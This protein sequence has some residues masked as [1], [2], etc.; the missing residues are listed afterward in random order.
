[1]LGKPGS[2]VDNAGNHAPEYRDSGPS[3][4]AP[5]N[6]RSSSMESSRASNQVMEIVVV[7]SVSQR[8]FDV[9]KRERFYDAN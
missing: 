8:G 7:F 6:H 2:D 9:H 3:A 5:T 1:M 4:L